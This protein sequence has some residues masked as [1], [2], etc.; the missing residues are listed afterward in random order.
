MNI[1]YKIYI[2]TTPKVNYYILENGIKEA[3]IKKKTFAALIH[4]RGGNKRLTEYKMDLVDCCVT[5]S[6]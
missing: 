5:L 3:I 2:K 4:V 1:F 6:R